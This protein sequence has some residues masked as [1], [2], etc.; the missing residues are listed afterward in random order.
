MDQ[1]IIENYSAN[2]R[3]RKSDSSAFT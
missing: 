3:L 1:I 2:A